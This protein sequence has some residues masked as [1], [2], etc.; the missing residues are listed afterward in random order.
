MAKCGQILV[1]DKLDRSYNALPNKDRFCRT[2][3][4]VPFIDT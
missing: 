4:A 3:A 1:T 2:I